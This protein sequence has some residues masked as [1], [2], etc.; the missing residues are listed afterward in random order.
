MSLYVPLL[1]AQARIK[2]PHPGNNSASTTQ[3]VSGHK[4]QERQG[5][6]YVIKI[7]QNSSTDTSQPTA[8]NSNEK[9]KDLPE[10]PVGKAPEAE[11]AQP[12]QIADLIESRGVLTPRG[13]M[14][15]EP[16]LQYTNS[17]VTRVALEGF[18]I[19]PALTI[20]SIDILG[21]DR[22]T[23]TA[24]FNLRYGVTSRL[25]L[26][27]RIPYVY[28][29]DTTRS[30]PLAEPAESD[31][32]VDA[33]GSD[34]GDIEVGVHYQFNHPASRR[35]HFI[36][37]LRVKTRTGT[38]PFDTET[39]PETGL[40]TQL[41]TG[42]G[43]WGVQPSLTISYPSDPAVFFGNLSYL[44]NIERRIDDARGEI[45]PGDAVGVSFGMGFSI[46][47]DA[48]FTLGYSHNTVGK[49]EQNGNNIEGSERL[50]IGTLLY[51]ITHRAGKGGSVSLTVGAGVTDD[52]PDVQV[53]LRVP[54]AFTLFK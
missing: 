45:N 9:Q 32:A 31:K 50:H 6:A 35:P 38:D 44:W 34:L 17:S 37:N 23:L 27:A 43:F 20:G 39:D 2:T 28:R 1:N 53:S 21:V 29:K 7:T 16:S 11:K 49:T 14:I 5:S 33:E 8:S 12:L 42:S 24:A 48:S 13:M 15:I 4:R 52:A 22:N 51:G 3:H 40:Q 47:N 26:E 19:I 54:V 25:E 10:Q 30:R 36:A 41:P 46:N 18:T